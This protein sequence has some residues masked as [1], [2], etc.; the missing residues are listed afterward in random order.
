MT[1]LEDTQ[2]EKSVWEGEEE[3]ISIYQLA[4]KHIHQNIM[5]TVARALNNISFFSYSNIW[6]MRIVRRLVY[7]PILLKV[8]L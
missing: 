2:Q 6:E 8:L 3:R 7:N 1:V 5:A 4:R